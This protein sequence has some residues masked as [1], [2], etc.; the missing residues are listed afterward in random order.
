M[1][2]VAI[3]VI[4]LSCLISLREEI[5]YCIYTAK[6][7]SILSIYGIPIY[8]RTHDS[9]ES[10][11]L[12]E[13]FGITGPVSYKLFRYGHP[14][15]IMPSTP[16]GN[17][18]SLRSMRYRYERSPESHPEIEEYIRELFSTENPEINP[19]DFETIMGR[20]EATSRPV[21]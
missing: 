19:D 17:W 20:N 4:L 1:L 6:W 16:K 11:W 21:E 13:E 3:V 15:L 18:L 10:R 5:D 8:E 7:R 12:R 9:S 14:A 2:I